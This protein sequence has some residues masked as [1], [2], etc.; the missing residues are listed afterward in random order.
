V[1]VFVFSP[2]E[3]AYQTNLTGKGATD[4]TRYVESRLDARVLGSGA[5]VYAFAWSS[6]PGTHSV[7]L[8]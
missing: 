4:A 5:G 7:I 2:Y 1:V 8:P 3:A 6:P